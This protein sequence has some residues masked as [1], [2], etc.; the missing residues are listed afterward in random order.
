MRSRVGAQH[1]CRVWCGAPPRGPCSL[2]ARV[3]ARPRRA[4]PHLCQR[5]AA[6]EVEAPQRRALRHHVAQGHAAAQVQ[7]LERRAAA[8]RAEHEAAEVGARVEAEGL[9]VQRRE[10]EQL[11][12][13]RVAHAGG[14]LDADLRARCVVQLGRV[15]WLRCGG[16]LAGRA[17]W[18]P[19]RWGGALR[20]VWFPQGAS[21]AFKHA[22]FGGARPCAAPGRVRHLAARAC[23]PRG[24]T[25][26][27]ARAAPPRWATRLH[28]HN[29][30][31]G[32][33]A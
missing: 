18:E 10:A 3:P 9:E 28:L 29:E 20:G 8:E 25:P 2:S 24:T 22:G 17:R 12:R 4:C 14:L 1:V 26:A 5:R 16:W 6:A 30:A 21:A 27:R 23:A 15:G 33:S 13:E 11:R 32:A 7:P 31:A 19:A